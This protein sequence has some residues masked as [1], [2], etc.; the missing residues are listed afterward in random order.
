[1]N[2][3]F[4]TNT[5][6]YSHIVRSARLSVPLVCAGSEVYKSQVPGHHGVFC[7]VTIFMDPQYE[8]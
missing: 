4:L 3:L 7:M 5:I 1:M 8:T 2:K 6:S